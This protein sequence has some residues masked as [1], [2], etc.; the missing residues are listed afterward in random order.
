MAVHLLSG[1]VAPE[2]AVVALAQLEAEHRALYGDITPA[3]VGD[4]AG[5]WDVQVVDKA[6][7]SFDPHQV[8][9]VEACRRGI[10][11]TGDPH[12]AA[13]AQAVTST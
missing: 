12:F 11:L 7:S 2:H 4:T 9:L 10:G 5:E 6:V 3:A 13:A 8:K 1:H